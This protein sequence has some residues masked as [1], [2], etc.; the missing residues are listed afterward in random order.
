[1]ATLKRL[2]W[3]V[4]SANQWENTRGDSISLDEVAPL[5]VKKLVARDSQDSVWK[6]ASLKH[7]HI[8][9]VGC[10]PLL[11]PIVDLLTK[12]DAKKNWGAKQQATLRSI[13]AGVFRNSAVFRAGELVKKAFSLF[14]VLVVFF[15]GS[16]LRYKLRRHINNPLRVAAA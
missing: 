8:A 2:R 4:L 3:K 10:V 14:F 15:A 11:A 6:Q 12:T 7:P 1:M 9:S 13:T 16:F 5:S